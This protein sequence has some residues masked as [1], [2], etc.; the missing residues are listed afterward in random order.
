MK[1]SLLI[2]LSLLLVGGRLSA[3]QP[4]RLRRRSRAGGGHQ[5]L[6]EPFRRAKERSGPRFQGQGPLHRSLSCRARQ[7]IAYSKLSAE[8]KAMIND[9][10]KAMCSDY[11]PRACLEVAKETGDNQRFLTFFGEPLGKTSFAWHIGMYHLTLVY[12]EFG[13]DKAN[14]FGP[15][16][17]G[18]NPAKTIWDARKNR[19]RAVRRP[20]PDE[21][22]DIATRTKGASSDS[23]P[24]SARPAC[25]SAISM[26]KP[27]SSPSVSCRNAWKYFR[28]IVAR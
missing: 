26:R 4:T 7:G 1:H 25:A 8:Q 18:G 22:K 11:G 28:P 10:V 13:T 21:V 2:A 17:L 19:H 24:P 5:A 3:P 20:F 14:E 27:A 9:V 16:L 15:I 12:A 23:G 6:P